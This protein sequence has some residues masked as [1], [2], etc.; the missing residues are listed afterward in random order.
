MA[1]QFSGWAIILVGLLGLGGIIGN[2]VDGGGTSVLAL[3]AE[4]LLFGA[5]SALVCAAKRERVR[6]RLLQRGA[7][8]DASGQP[9]FAPLVKRAALRHEGRLTASRAAAST[10]LSFEEARATLTALARAGQCQILL[11]EGGALE[12]HFPSSAEQPNAPRQAARPLWIASSEERPM[13]KG[14]PR[15]L[16]FLPYKIRL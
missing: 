2:A 6:A 14:S 3:F 1:K 13:K 11:G 10:R 7:E 9:S 12:Y 5:G 15:R 16:F 4:L 8:L